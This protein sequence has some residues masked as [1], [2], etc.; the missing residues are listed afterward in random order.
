MHVNQQ[1]KRM[2]LT[3]TFLSS[4]SCLICNTSSSSS[5]SLASHLRLLFEAYPL[6]LQHFVNFKHLLHSDVVVHV[7][8]PHQIPYAVTPALRIFITQTRQT[9]LLLPLKSG[10]S[11]HINRAK[12]LV[13]PAQKKTICCP[14][15]EDIPNPIA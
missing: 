14:L 5:P 15:L 8:Q 7:L 4:A 10:A 13:Y 12:R 11:L 9:K 6:A 3:G 1:I 2:P